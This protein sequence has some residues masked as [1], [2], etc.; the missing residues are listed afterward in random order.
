MEKPTNPCNLST[1]P[2]HLGLD[3]EDTV[4]GTA[5][6]LSDVD[7]VTMT[8]KDGSVWLDRHE[9]GRYWMS[10]RIRAHLR[11]NVIGYVALF[12]AIGGTAMALPGGNTV[13]SGDII[14]G[15][16]KNQDLTA[17]AVTSGKIAPQE[18][19]R[20]DL[21]D[22]AVDSTKVKDESLTSSDLGADSAGLAEIDQSAFFS[23]DISN[24]G[25]PGSPLQITTGG[26]DSGDI[27]NSAVHAAELGTITQRSATSATIAAGGNGSVTASCLAGERVL[28]GGNDGFF[29]VFVVAS[30]Q[31]GNGW[32]VF[33]HNSS[34]GNRT[35]TA[36]AY[37][38]E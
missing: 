27:G 2:T 31:S 16:V 19:R 23:G 10:N 13:N 21:R 18:V 1:E 35:I 3:P 32:A 25:S 15:E 14:N 7:R 5:S 8:G 38:L 24:D 29:D 33:V 22:T 28:S 12:F 30:R 4:A 36:H 20:A 6:S 11:S 9:Q 26:V 37:C 34:G 17:D